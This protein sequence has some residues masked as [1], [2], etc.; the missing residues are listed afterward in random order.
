M[1]KLICFIKGICRSIPQLI[2]GSYPIS[3][4]LFVDQEYHKGC[5]VV[6]G[7]CETCGKIDISWQ[8]GKEVD[9]LEDLTYSR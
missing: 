3:G 1:E 5:D 8:G 6:I 2:D 9:N 4:H 7:K